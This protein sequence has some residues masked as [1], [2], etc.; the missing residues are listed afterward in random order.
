MTAATLTLADFLL[1]RIDEDEALAR[2][3][4]HQAQAGRPLLTL[5]GG[6]TAL[7]ELVDPARVL[8]E[9]AAKRAIVELH[10]AFPRIAGW[11]EAPTVH[12]ATCSEC[13]TTDWDTNTYPCPTIRHLAT[14]YADHPD[15]SPEWRP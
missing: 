4:Q 6:G 12:C 1:A 7:R 15:Y 8:A 13:C 3:M 10:A 2:D 9:C 5:N 14:I 11:D